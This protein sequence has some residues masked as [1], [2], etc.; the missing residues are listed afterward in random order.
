MNDYPI[1]EECGNAIPEYTNHCPC[2]GVDIYVAPKRTTKEL[3]DE[4]FDDDGDLEV[5]PTLLPISPSGSDIIPYTVTPYSDTAVNKD[6]V[7]TN[8]QSPTYPAVWYKTTDYQYSK[9]D[10]SG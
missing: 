6:Y 7:G 3:M 8:I 1:C 5:Y 2:C 4:V 10:K 9:S